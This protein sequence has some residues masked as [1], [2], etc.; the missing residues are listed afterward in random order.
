MSANDIAG[1]LAEPFDPD[2]LS[3]KPGAVS[4]SRA[5]GLAYVT[6]R[7]VMDRLDDVLGV[8]GWQ[9]SYKVLADSC[10]MCKLHACLGDRWVTKTDVG[11]PSEQ[12]DDGDKTKAAFSDA[13]KRYAVKYGVARYLGR[14]PR[15]WC[16]YDPKSRQLTP[17]PLPVWATPWISAAQAGE[18]AG[19]VE[20]AGVDLAKFLAHFAIGRVSHLPASRYAEALGKLRA[21]Q[22]GNG[23]AGKA[24]AGRPLPQ[25]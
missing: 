10:V 17:P 8:A 24:A 2:E 16:D 22:Q 19:L 1:R 6:A 3:W 9:D 12:P 11:S 25:G 5:L 7:A 13:L 18:L 21:R 20:V 14:L 23:T 15:V 4:G